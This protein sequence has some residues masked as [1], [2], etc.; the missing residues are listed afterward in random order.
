M[1][2][3]WIGKKGKHRRRSDRVRRRWWFSWR[4]EFCEEE[5]AKA[6]HRQIDVSGIE[7]SHV[8]M[9]LIL[10]RTFESARWMESRPVPLFCPPLLHFHASFA[11][12]DWFWRNATK[13]PSRPIVQDPIKTRLLY[14]VRMYKKAISVARS[15][16]VEPRM[17]NRRM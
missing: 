5:R 3:G 17:V 14:L 4:S 10:F 12:T 8:F 15:T 2:V 16:S 7:P 13:P 9:I 1:G 6:H 11:R